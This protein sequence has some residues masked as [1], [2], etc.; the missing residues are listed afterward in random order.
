MALDFAIL[1]KDGTPREQVSIRVDAHHRLMQ[2]VRNTGA[3]RLERVA[4]YYEDAE[5]A[6]ADIPALL[7]EIE[8]LLETRVEDHDVVTFLRSLKDLASAAGAAKL[9]II[10]IAD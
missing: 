2:L 10:V 4:D 8:T 7:G 9:P 1:A 6:S 3:P 5:Y